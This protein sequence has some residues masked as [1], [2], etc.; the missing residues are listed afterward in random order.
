MKEKYKPNSQQKMV[1][2]III[3]GEEILNDRI[4]AGAFNIIFF[5][6]L[7]S[8]LVCSNE[9]NDGNF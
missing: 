5:S 7:L 8:Y 3:L 6:L 1:K 9:S 4:L 2:S